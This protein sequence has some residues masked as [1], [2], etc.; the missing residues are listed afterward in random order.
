MLQVVY[1]AVRDKRLNEMEEALNNRM[2]KDPEVGDR[3]RRQLAEK[4]MVSSEFF[5]S[6]G[7]DTTLQ[8]LEVA[9]FT[10]FEAGATI[11][12]AGDKVRSAYVVYDGK[13]GLFSKQSISIAAQLVELHS[14]TRNHHKK[15]SK[16]KPR[17]RTGKRNKTVNNLLPLGSSAASTLVDEVD[18]GNMLMTL[19]PVTLLKAGEMFGGEGNEVPSR[20]QAA[21]ALEACSVIKIPREEYVR[22]SLKTQMKLHALKLQAIKRSP[23]EFILSSEAEVGRRGGGVVDCGLHPPPPP[24]YLYPLP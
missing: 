1:M 3:A 22:L 5:A 4:Y 17:R 15:S 11:F 21:I 9:N 16:P 13:V 6:N 24:S 2:S 20:L 12:S 8:L 10:R 18:I 14:G 19:K 23:F 7:F